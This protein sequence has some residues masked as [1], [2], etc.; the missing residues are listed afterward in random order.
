MRDKRC[1]CAC[2]LPVLHHR[3]LVKAIVKAEDA[4]RQ[5]MRLSRLQSF[6]VQKPIFDLHVGLQPLVPGPFSQIPL[7]ICERFTVSPR[8]SVASTFLRSEPLYRC[9]AADYATV[10]ARISRDCAILARVGGC[11]ASLRHQRCRA[12]ADDDTRCASGP[13]AGLAHQQQSA[14]VEKVSTSLPTAQTPARPPAASSGSLPFVERRGNKVRDTICSWQQHSARAHSSGPAQAGSC[15]C[16][17]GGQRPRATALLPAALLASSVV[18]RD[19]SQSKPF[20]RLP[21]IGYSS[22]AGAPATWPALEHT[23]NSCF[24]ELPRPF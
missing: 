15:N 18:R 11:R 6:A 14:H 19:F 16:V 17:V 23:S 13:A 5:Q 20:A 4:H 24:L 9:T 3:W 10:C 1:A 7:G 8:A 2:A 12:A 21:P 22:A